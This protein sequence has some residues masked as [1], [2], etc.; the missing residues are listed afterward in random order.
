M[1]LK[2]C[3]KIS[4]KGLTRYIACD[5]KFQY[6]DLLNIVVDKFNIPLDYKSAIDFYDE[7]GHKY[8]KDT[9]EYFLM[10]FPNPK[11]IFFIRL[12]STKMQT[13]QQQHNDRMPFGKSKVNNVTLAEKPTE[14]TED[15]KA[16]PVTRQ[17]CFIGSWPSST[18]NQPTFNATE[19]M[20]ALEIVQRMKQ[21]KQTPP[22]KK[23]LNNSNN[24]KR[25]LRI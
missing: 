10:L 14:T 2:N 16:V 25:S 17:N 6:D 21:I 24:F 13:T 7:L 15:C 20:L 4:Y 5:L 18:Q 1:T 19:E 23:R 12:D 9:F 22:K 3:L 11:K 8:N